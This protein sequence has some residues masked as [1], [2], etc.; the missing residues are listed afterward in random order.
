[1]RVESVR[2]EGDRYVVRPGGAV[3]EADDVI[4]ASGAHGEPRVPSSRERSRPD[5]VQLHSSE[6]RNPSQLRDGGVLVVGAGN[7]GGDIALELARTHPTWVS[8]P[9]RGSIPFDIDTWFAAERRR[10]DRAVRRAP[11]PDAPHADRPQ[12]GGEVR[13]A[14]RAAV[15]VK[16]KWLTAAG[17]ELVSKTVGTRDGLPM[18]EDGRVL[19]VANVIWC[20]GYRHDLSWLELPIFGDDGTVLHERGVVQSE[21]GVYFVGLPFQ[22]SAGRTRSRAWGATPR[23]SSG[24]WWSDASRAPML[25]AA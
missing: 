15:R 24:G 4:V 6:Y 14:G 16:P 18:L 23:S 12:G 3:F 2:R 7:S 19:D 10:A 11:R 20:T 13:R 25:A 9:I 21:P 22:Y 1:M 5:I 8:G 17:V